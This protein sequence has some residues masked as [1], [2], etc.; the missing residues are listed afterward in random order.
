MQKIY[1]DTIDGQIHCLIGGSG[2]PVILLHQ[3]PLSFDSFIEVAEFLSKSSTVC[4]I[5]TL[6]FGNSDKP[7]MK[8]Q[9]KDYALNVIRVMDNL[10]IQ[11]ASIAG[12]HTGANI[13]IEIGVAY[14]ER[15]EKLILSAVHLLTSE[16]REA[17]LKGSLFVS[18]DITEDGAFLIKMWDNLR[19]Y[20]SIGNTI[21]TENA[22]PRL[23]PE[24]MLRIFL[25]QL[26]AGP[27]YTEAALASFSYDAEAQLSKIKA[28]TLAMT[29]DLDA[30]YESLEKVRRLIPHCKSKV[31]YGSADAVNYEKPEEFA[32]AISDFISEQVK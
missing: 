11:R 15:T 23:K 10:S 3:S 24:V 32:R 18:T 5:D 25:D 7:K 17:L 4:A 1:V 12:H 20:F 27:R 8:P 2:K 22:K 28:P 21:N 26:R 30:A 6:G 13:A 19:H 16:Q 9:I 14:P 31:F 29:G